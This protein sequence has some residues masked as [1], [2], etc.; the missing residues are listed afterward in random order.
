MNDYTVTNVPDQL[1]KSTEKKA[2]D[3]QHY[4]DTIDAY[5][6]MSKFAEYE[7]D[8]EDLETWYKVYNGEKIEGH[9]A[10][11]EDPF[12]TK[13]T[14][15]P[16]P[17]NDVK[18]WN[19]IRSN[20]DIIINEKNKRPWNYTSVIRSDD[21]ISRRTEEME[22]AIK[23]AMRKSIVNMANK[24]GRNTGVPMQDVP[25]MESIQLQY[26]TSYQD[27][28]AIRAQKI[29]KVAISEANV[30]EKLNREGMQHWVIGGMIKTFKG[31]RQNGF[32]YNVV[33][34]LHL[35][36]IGSKD[37]KYG[38]DKEAAIYRVMMPFSKIVDN[39]RDML[40]EDQIERLSQGP[41]WA[42]Q[43]IDYTKFG[44]HK[45]NQNNNTGALVEV[46]HS[47]WRSF[48]YIGIIDYLDEF[49]EPQK[50][51]VDDTFDKK[52]FPYAIIDEKW[53][54]R[55][56]VDETYRIDG[57]IYIGMNSVPWTSHNK[58][59]PSLV[60][61]PYNEVKFSDLNAKN[62]SLV[63]EAYIYQFFHNI[64][65]AKMERLISVDKGEVSIIDRALL[66]EQGLG[67]ADI[68]K[69]MYFIET[70]HILWVDSRRDDMGK[71]AHWG[72]KMNF[73]QH[74]AV[75]SLI[76]VINALREELDMSMGI[77]PQRKGEVSNSAGKAATEYALERSY[78]ISEGV[79]VDFENFEEEELNDIIDIAKRVYSSVSG[80]FIVDG[81]PIFLDPEE[82]DISEESLGVYMSK[83]SKD[84]AK[85][86]SLRALAQPFAQ[87]VGK[88]GI[89]PDMI[90]SILESDNMSEITMAMKKADMAIK[91]YETQQQE[92]ARQMQ[93]D[94]IEAEAADK[95]AER[96]WKTS[97]NALDR[98]RDIR[99]AE[100]KSAGF[101]PETLISDIDTTGIIRDA[102]KIRQ[103]S[104][105]A[106]A[107][108]E[109]LGFE[110]QKHA[111][112]LK[113]AEK[114]R[115]HEQK[116]KDKDLKNKVV[117]E[118]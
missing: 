64:W 3:F 86:D 56:C 112:E 16:L 54:W 58:Y 28:R 110:K 33:N 38:R 39:F 116:L 63:K 36:F 105:K 118:K 26:E 65:K 82:E 46:V 50:M 18:P 44:L 109:K 51:E 107:D 30:R 91:A 73:S 15:N 48:Q 81:L 111:D 100:I 69:A 71:F 31:I 14:T 101:E 70:Q 97:E 37:Y 74:Q 114:N 55:T 117:G 106:Q 45:M 60:N 96:D 49:D 61:L 93:Q 92:A 113:E 52:I 21:A 88:Q 78:N 25:S 80:M 13:D 40:D 99:E 24:D 85:V 5:I 42:D 27:K 77:T 10:A 22:T 35:D 19:V 98:E 6:S 32:V 102:D 2:E 75:A 76:Q 12:G 8:K 1:K 7:D 68:D 47:T 34:P 94:K 103:A 84:K 90:K 23:D 9:Y 62:T 89:T 11:F 17:L 4:K 104:S 95:Q 41:S 108:R 67:Q 83:A 79:F 87:N 72:S 29:M 59:N 53:E 43:P 115:K 20:V 57:D 66:A